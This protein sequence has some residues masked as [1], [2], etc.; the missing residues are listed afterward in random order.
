MMTRIALASLFVTSLVGCTDEPIS[1]SEPVG[2][3]L[4]VTSADV[5]AGVV[6]DDKNINT[7]SGN[8][9][10]AFITNARDQLA[11]A[12]P[13]AITVDAGT[14][15]LATTS[16]NVTALD[17]I[18]ANDVD[19]MFEIN[20][21]NNSYLAATGTVTAGAGA[22]PLV[23]EDRFDSA[24]LPE[25]DYLK[26]VDGNFKVIVRGPATSAFMTGNADADLELT[27]TFSAF[28]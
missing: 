21:S 2:L 10:G 25:F 27:L 9:Y 18:F 24:A 22:G 4:K 7:E 6:S 13:S 19:V 20:D 11:G 28:E 8:P 1:Y 16:K 14:L 23:L 17:Q 26:L 12:R 5:T 3:H 15:Q